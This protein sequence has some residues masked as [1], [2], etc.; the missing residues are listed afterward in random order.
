MMVLPKEIT[1]SNVYP[2]SAS[3][4]IV[5]VFPVMALAL[6][7]I[8]LAQSAG[9]DRLE[10]QAQGQALTSSHDPAV[11]ITFGPQFKYAGGQ[12]FPLYGVAEAEQHFYVQANSS[13]QLQ[14]FYWVQF[15][16]YLPDNTHQYDYPSK[17]KVDIGGLS[18]IHDS[19]VFSD[20]AGANKNPDS[21]GG[22]ARALLRK[23]GM[24]FPSAM[25]RI[26]MVH[27]TDNS[28]RKELMI[29]YGEALD[30][31]APAGSEEGQEADD[32]FPELASGLLKHATEG[33]KIERH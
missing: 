16:H 5:K 4:V 33:M 20:Y 6:S 7:A 30:G 29:I 21:D 15:E 9:S 32:K 1:D 12:R 3:K 27:L 19:A 18:F 10:R 23:S 2:C 28:R 13:G 8:L 11:Q 14:R 26:R 25:A 17:R 24:V 22:K 31:K